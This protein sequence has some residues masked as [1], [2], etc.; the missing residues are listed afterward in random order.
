MTEEVFCNECVDAGY[1][2]SVEDCVRLECGCESAQ[3]VPAED[4]TN[5]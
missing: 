1:S 5:G 3:G 2:H 4:E